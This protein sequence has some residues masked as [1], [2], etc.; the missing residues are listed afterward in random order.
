MNKLLKTIVAVMSLCAV[1]FLLGTTA[2]AAEEDYEYTVENGEACIT[3]YLGSDTEVVI[4]AELGGYPVTSIGEYAFYACLDILSIRVPA[5]VTTIHDYAFATCW[6]MTEIELPAG[7]TSIGVGAFYYCLDLPSITIP[8]G[9]TE[10]PDHAFT[11]CFALNEVNLPSTM[12]SIGVSAFE[13]CTGLTE[14]AIP[15]GVTTIGTDAFINCSSLKAVEISPDVTEIGAYAFGYSKSPDGTYTLNEFTI[16]G[17]N[18]SAAEAY[19]EEHGIP[20][21]SNGGPVK[22]VQVTGVRAVY[23]DGAIKLTWD[24]CGAKYYKVSRSDGRSGYQNL[25]YKATADGWV[26]ENLVTAQLYFYRITG[27]FE[28]V[29]GGLISGDVSVATAAV[30]TD[31]APDK[32]TNVTATVTDGTVVLDWDAAAGS[33]YYKI[34]RASGATGKYYTMKFNVEDTTYTDAAVSRGTY[35]YKVVGYYKDVDGGWVYGELCDT[36]YVTVQ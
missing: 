20:F 22:P 11:M 4:P 28:D 33:R 25:T 6:C 15:E 30:A 14:F 21:I 13:Y 1:V 9:V 10:L 19:A 18:C 17:H 24:D 27:Y 3:A 12:T 5:T 7:L 34:S 35:R 31:T 16:T 2:K 8:S 36:L 29:N 32:V 23:E 26:D